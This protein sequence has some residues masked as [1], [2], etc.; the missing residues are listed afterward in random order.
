VI[1]AYA[2]GAGLGHLTR[3]RAVAH[4]LHIPEHELVVLTDSRHAGDERVVGS[5]GVRPPPARG[6][7]ADW[8]RDEVAAL[9][10]DELWVDAFPAGLDGE[11]DADL[12]PVLRAHGTRVVHVARLLQWPAYAPTLPAA[13]LRFDRTIV[14]EPLVEGH[15]RAVEELSASTQ[16]L[17][18]DDPPA[19][20]DL[21]AS[22]TVEHADRPR[23]LVAHAGPPEETAELCRY[24]SD[25]AD[26][27]GVEPVLLVAAPGA[28]RPGPLDLD[29]RP[30]L[31]L[32]AYPTWPLHRL[33]DVV[34]T[35][36]GFNS[37]RQAAGLRRAG[38]HRFVPFRRRYDDQFLRARRARQEHAEA[39]R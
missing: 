26:A 25:V 30:V 13:P 10:P 32:D 36:A 37:M 2:R 14:V 1:A 11:L 22:A 6:P 12:E 39:L 19:T 31:E 7:T 23:W 16:A 5:M 3:L 9:A 29:P 20:A 18:L 21:V 17:E 4:T 27:E 35:A 38:R 33:V 15:R 24:A 28:S 8:L 34:V